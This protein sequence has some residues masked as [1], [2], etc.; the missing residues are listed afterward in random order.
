M[1]FVNNI[2]MFVSLCFNKALTRVHLLC[3]PKQNKA[4]DV[5]F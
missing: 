1:S 5:W 4:A 3:V 2:H